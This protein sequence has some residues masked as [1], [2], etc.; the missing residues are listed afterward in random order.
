MTGLALGVSAAAALVYERA[1]KV[2]ENE[3]RPLSEVLAEMP[4]R[5][6]ADLGTI[7]DDLRDA[8][9]E[10]REAAG[11]REQEIDEELRAA[12]AGSAAGGP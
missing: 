7:G 11:R 12:R 9:E 2:A 1:R 3:G 8:A 6:M 10:G 4:S 5:L